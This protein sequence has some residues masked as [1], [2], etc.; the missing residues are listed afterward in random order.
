LR[1]TNFSKIRITKVT[2]FLNWKSLVWPNWTWPDFHPRRISVKIRYLIGHTKHD[3]DID[4]IFK[5]STNCFAFSDHSY[6]SLKNT[7]H[8]I[9][10]PSSNG[11]SFAFLYPGWEFTK[12]LTQILNIFCN[13]GPSNLEITMSLSSFWSRYHNLRKIRLLDQSWD[14]SQG[15]YC[16]SREVL[17]EPW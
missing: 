10:W 11:F 17:T 7:W 14:H 4:S 8:S 9:Y 16:H 6:W 13:F 1:I 12:I 3:G 15:G 2:V 5:D